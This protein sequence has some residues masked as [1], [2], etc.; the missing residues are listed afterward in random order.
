MFLAIT[1]ALVSVLHGEVSLVASLVIQRLQSVLF[2]MNKVTSSR[3][4]LALPKKA[5][6]PD[7]FWT[8]FEKNISVDFLC[9]LR[10]SWT[11]NL[12]WLH[13]SPDYIINPS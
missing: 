11:F 5:E 2:G 9:F 6:K 13:N 4:F 10:K 8:W 3:K 1:W 12:S 7:Q